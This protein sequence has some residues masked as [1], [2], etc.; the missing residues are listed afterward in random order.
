M[1]SIAVLAIFGVKSLLSCVQV[2]ISAPSAD[3]QMF[4][5]GVNEE[6]YD[7]RSHHV[8]S[9][10]SCTTNC[11]APLAKVGISACHVSIAEQACVEAIPA[12]LC[13]NRPLTLVAGHPPKVW[14]QRRS[15]DHSPCHNC[16]T[17]DGRWA[18]QEGLEG[19]ESSSRQHHPL[20][21]RGCQGRWQSPS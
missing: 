12:R 17:K 6:K 5:I 3:A 20:L 14:H 19:W 2:I 21:H 16:N 18:E 13:H 7:P 10:A 15:D 4:V 9:N 11:L 1:I 8:I